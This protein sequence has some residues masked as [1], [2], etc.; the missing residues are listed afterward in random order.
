[1]A[2][3][4]GAPLLPL[5]DGSEKLKKQLSVELYMQPSQHEYHTA[6]SQTTSSYG[7]AP[8]PSTQTTLYD[9]WRTKKDAD[10]LDWELYNNRRW[11]WRHNR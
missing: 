6:G 11:R 9:F 1:M 8:V 2:S 3:N 4:D 7:P 5:K 10:I